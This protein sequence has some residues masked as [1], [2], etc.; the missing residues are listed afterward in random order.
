MHA[1]ETNHGLSLMGWYKRPPL[2][3][4]D[5]KPYARWIE[6]TNVWK[7]LTDL[8]GNKQGIATTL[9][10]PEHDSSGIRDKVFSDV[11]I[12]NLKGADGIDKSITYMDKIFKKDELSDIYETFC[13]FDRF[14]RRRADISMEVY[15]MDFEKLYKITKKNKMELPEAVEHLSF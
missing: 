5:H 14:H 2:F 15:V 10:L 13:D 9:S 11:A 7:E 4:I 8:T 6:E 1:Q 12:D 3:K